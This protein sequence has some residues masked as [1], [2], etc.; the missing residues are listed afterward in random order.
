MS[1]SESQKGA[2][3]R[4]VLIAELACT[5]IG[6]DDLNI[7]RC[8]SSFLTLA[9]SSPPEIN[10]IICSLLHLIKCMESTGVLKG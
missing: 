7:N 6:Q 8:F 1:D 2:N 3:G 9:E 10:L 4:V 5:L